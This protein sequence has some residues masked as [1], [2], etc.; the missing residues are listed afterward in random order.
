VGFGLILAGSV[1]QASTS[2]GGVVFLGPVPIVFG[3]GPGGWA[4]ALLSVVVGAVM[5][6]LLLVWTWRPART[7]SQ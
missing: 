1:G 3:S 6:I 2:V 5:V 4:L 7:K